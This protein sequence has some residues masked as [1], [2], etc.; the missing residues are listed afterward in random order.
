MSPRD[1]TH[2]R[3]TIVS[4]AS[5]LLES[6]GPDA[7]TLRSVGTAAG[8][9]RS[10]PY[11]HFEDKAELLAELALQTLIDLTTS[12]RNRDPLGPG[13][14]LRQGCL[15][16]LRY[17]RTQEHHYQLIFGDR[18]I[19]EPSAALETAADDGIQAFIELVEQA[20]TDG[21]L[22]QGP[23]RELATLIWALLHGL[24][25]LQITGHLREPRTPEGDI[26]VDELLTLALDTLHP[27]SP[28]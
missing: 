9:S 13:S 27:K 5:S 2:T 25:H 22:A 4:A 17:A 1:G 14:H 11:R 20:Q 24:A 19:A 6:G 15:G 12:I 23:P 21:E 16:Y 18:P 10:A 7:V 8:V 26:G 3:T 28:A